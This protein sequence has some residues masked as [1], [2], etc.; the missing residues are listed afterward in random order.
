[1]KKDF[2]MALKENRLVALSLEDKIKGLY[3]RVDSLELKDATEV[4]LEALEFPVL[5]AKK[6]LQDQNN[7]EV[8]VYLV[9]SDLTLD[10]DGMFKI[11]QKRWKIEEFFK[12]MKS[13]CSY[14][15][16]PTQTVTTQSNHFFCSVYAVFKYEMMRLNTNL[17]HFALKS[18]IYLSAMKTAMVQ[19]QLFKN[20]DNFVY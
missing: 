19:L 9:S 16:S 1:M 11:Y 14:S 20:L 4:Y 12:S 8:D 3:Q 18:K 7:K 6:V 17:N 5:I 13:N 2:V 15:K 10:T